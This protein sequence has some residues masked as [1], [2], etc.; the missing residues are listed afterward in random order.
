MKLSV[1]IVNYNVKY[2]LEQCLLSVMRATKNIESE[3]Y[4]VDNCSNDD[5][6][7]Y[8]IPKFPE[9]IFLENIENE[10]FA[11][12][13]NR[14]MLLCKGEYI[15]LLNPDTVIGEYVLE[16]ICRFMDE[17]K[18]AGGVGVKMING[19]GVFLPESKRGFP[20]PWTSFCK[21]FGISKLFPQ[22]RI[23]GKY[24]LKYLDKNQIH[25]I[26]VMAGAFMMLRKETLDKCGLLDEVFFMYGED[27]DLSY[28]ITL[29]GYKNYYLP[30]TII[31]YK[32]ESTQKNDIK[33][34]T[35]FYRAMLIFFR[36]HYPKFGK[37]YSFLI[38]FAVGIRASLAI[39]KRLI[40]RC[41]GIVPKKTKPSG[42]LI[43][44]GKK[45]FEKVKR[46][47]VARRN[48]LPII[49]GNIDIT[50]SDFC[51]KIKSRSI[52]DVVFSNEMPFEKIIELMETTPRKKAFK[53]FCKESGCMISSKES[54][55][56]Y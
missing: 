44:A 37:Y 3:I 1:V 42:V 16:N 18:T 48:D 55:S 40:K 34:V 15:L 52:S 46:F 21:I 23:F 2:F 47:Y 4:V 51:E 10:G 24:H 41:F 22:S 38:Y 50:E 30:E 27:I 45:V 8:L 5:S 53:I 13:N 39:L 29:A 11:K 7:N 9:V 54:Y 17:H 49:A 28:R 26:D 6:L 20:S 36:K 12:A 19:E 25:E 43:I 56:V 33:Y 31:H 32:G 14:A 35:V